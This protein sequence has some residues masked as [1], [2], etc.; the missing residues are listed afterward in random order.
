MICR[1]HVIYY[2]GNYYSGNKIPSNALSVGS[3]G[4]SEAGTD[5]TQFKYVLLPVFGTTIAIK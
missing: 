3:P 2:S 4:G 1:R 5:G